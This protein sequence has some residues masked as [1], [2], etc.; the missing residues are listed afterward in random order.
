[1]SGSTHHGHLDLHL[2]DS[3]MSGYVIVLLGNWVTGKIGVVDLVGDTTVTLSTHR[4][5][6]GRL[7]PSKSKLQDAS[8]MMQQKEANR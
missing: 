8:R 2:D 5:S 6:K 4:R 7:M 1:M 3:C